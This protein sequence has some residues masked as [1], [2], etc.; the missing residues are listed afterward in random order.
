MRPFQVHVVHILNEPKNSFKAD[1][2]TSDYETDEVVPEIVEPS[3]PQSEELR[4]FETYNRTALP[5][6]VEAN[7]RAIVESQIAPIEERVRAMIVDIVRTAQ[8]TIARNFNSMNAPTSSADDET[9]PHSQTVRLAELGALSS[10]EPAQTFGID[11]A[12]HPSELYHE[13]PHLNAEASASFPDPVSIAIGSQYHSS[14]SGYS[15]LPFSCP[16][17]CHGYSNTWNTANSKKFLDR[18]P[19]SQ[20]MKK[21]R[22]FQLSIVRFYA[23]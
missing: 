6:L 14:D 11:G 12:D 7:L 16:C 8:S 19:G 2:I 17:S 10:E 3:S 1:H 13:P 9:Q 4:N 15:S 22:S 21:F 5:L 20:L 23:H 18:V